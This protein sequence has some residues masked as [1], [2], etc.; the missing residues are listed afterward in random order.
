[1]WRKPR[2]EPAIPALWP[3]DPAQVI[4]K[5]RHERTRTFLHRVLNPASVPEPVTE[6]VEGT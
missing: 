6:R 2:R 3:G 4:G 5:P 1:M